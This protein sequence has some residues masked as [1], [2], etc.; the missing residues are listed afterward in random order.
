[1]EKNTKDFSCGQ[2]LGNYHTATWVA[3]AK[4][5]ALWGTTDRELM[6]VEASFAAGFLFS[7]KDTKQ[8][9]VPVHKNNLSRRKWP[10]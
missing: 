9:K 4:K 7:D 3:I 2:N 5:E 8:R 6:S 10:K 1:M